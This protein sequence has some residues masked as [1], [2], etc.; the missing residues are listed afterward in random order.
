MPPMPNPGWSALVAVIVLAGAPALAQEPREE[1]HRSELVAWPGPWS[2][3]L[4][5]ATIIL[6]SDQELE[7]SF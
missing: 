1:T 4:P 7:S 2:F 5:H 3:L 6:V